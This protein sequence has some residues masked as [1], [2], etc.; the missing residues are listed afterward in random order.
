MHPPKSHGK[1]LLVEKVCLFPGISCQQ[2]LWGRTHLE[3]TFLI[4]L[5][6]SYQ[7]DLSIH[8]STDTKKD[9]KYSFA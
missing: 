4:T 9:L 8:V 1:T 7:V 2:G 6:E 5:W 3:M